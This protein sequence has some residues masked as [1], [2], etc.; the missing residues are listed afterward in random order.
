MLPSTQI[1]PV[2]AFKHD[3]PDL[4]SELDAQMRSHFLSTLSGERDITLLTGYQNG[5]S[6]NPSADRH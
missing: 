6:R 4:K 5:N 1:D 2:L 3:D